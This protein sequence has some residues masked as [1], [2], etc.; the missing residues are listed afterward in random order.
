MSGFKAFFCT[1]YDSLNKKHNTAFAIVVLSLMLFL[2][3]MNVTPRETIPYPFARTDFGGQYINQFDAFKKGQLYIDTEPESE[4]LELENPY[5]PY[6]R[7]KAK[8]YFLW[9]YALYEGK[10][11]SYFGVAPIFTVYFPFYAVTHAL[12][13]NSLAC[14]ILA[15]WS[16]FFLSLC[17]REMILRFSEKPNIFLFLLG[18]VS[19]NICSGVYLGA[20][21]ADVYYIAV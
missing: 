17:Y 3:F 8:V 2:L 21:C 12:P 10:Y 18:L 4:L 11:Y 16:V 9:D 14:L 7:D 20:L 19:V 15:L 13:N 1:K 6:E 5:D